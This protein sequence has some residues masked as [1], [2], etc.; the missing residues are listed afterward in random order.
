MKQVEIK[1]T[2]YQAKWRDDFSKERCVN[3]SITD[4]GYLLDIDG[5]GTDCDKEALEVVYQMI[6]LLIS[7]GA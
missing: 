7:E 4:D 6:G 3:I 1:T 5:Y 2:A